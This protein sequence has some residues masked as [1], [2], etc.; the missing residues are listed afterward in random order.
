MVDS[1]RPNALTSVFFDAQDLTF[2]LKALRM[3]LLELVSKAC[4]IQDMVNAC[5]TIAFVYGC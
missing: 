1:L 3:R 5:D 2:V 4:N